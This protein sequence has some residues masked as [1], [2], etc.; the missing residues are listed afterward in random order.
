M[1]RTA[2]EEISSISP[3]RSRWIAPGRIGFMSTQRWEDHSRL[4]HCKERVATSGKGVPDSTARNLLAV[5]AGRTAPPAMLPALLHPSDKD[6]SLGAPE[7]EATNSLLSDH[8]NQQLVR[9]VLFVF[10]FGSPPL[11]QA[12]VRRPLRQRPSGYPPIHSFAERAR[13]HPTLPG[14][15]A[16]L[17]CRTERYDGKRNLHLQHAA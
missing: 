15:P 2:R 6:L 4:A 3:A 9:L 1:I 7:L 8:R 11:R 10:R 14:V 13:S 16:A 17:S 12:A 5:A